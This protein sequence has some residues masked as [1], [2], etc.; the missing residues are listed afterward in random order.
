MNPDVPGTTSF[1]LVEITTLWGIA[2]CSMEHSLLY[3]AFI[4][5]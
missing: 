5:P 4:A 3:K 1:D 2:P